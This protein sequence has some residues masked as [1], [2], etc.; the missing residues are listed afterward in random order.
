MNGIIIDKQAIIWFA[1]GNKRLSQTAKS[2]IEDANQKCFISI[3]SL[4]EMAIKINLGK[5]SITNNDLQTFIGELEESGFTIL[6]ITHRH[7]VRYLDLHL[8]HRDPFDRLII[9]QAIVENLSVI[10]SDQ[11]FCEYPI[12]VVW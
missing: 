11:V 1:E 4:W 2:L 10:S 3:A 9:T 5:L 6:N 8:I 7:I 12:R